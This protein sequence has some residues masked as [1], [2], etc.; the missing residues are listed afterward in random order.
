MAWDPNLY[1]IFEKYRRQPAIDLLAHINLERP[2]VVF[3]LGCG[4]GNVTALLSE[5]WPSANIT[6][7]DSSS[8]MLTKA[9]EIYPGIAWSKQDISEFAAT[10]VD[11][12][13]SN[14]AFNWV[15]NHARLIASLARFLGEAGI[16]A[17]QMPRN[18]EQPSHAQIVDCIESRPSRHH[19]RQFV[20]FTHVQPPAFYHDVLAP[21]VRNVEIWE[22][23]YF[24]VLQGDDPVLEWVM[25]T[26]LRPVVN[27]LSGSEK[28]DFVE[29]MRQRYRDAYPRGPDGTTLFAMQR[30]FV[31]AQR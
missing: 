22:T 8:E 26:A 24:H 6:G 25:G 23:N 16:L 5:R 31:V 15:P 18:Y 3:D 19:L 4:P 14:A 27:A 21:L 13:F 1:L 12:I 7:V 11:L 29:E 30:L 9:A 10:D 20:D 2:K 28:R 17:I